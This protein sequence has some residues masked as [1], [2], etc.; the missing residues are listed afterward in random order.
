MISDTRGGE[1]PTGSKTPGG[2]GHTRQTHDPHKP[3]QNHLSPQSSEL[4]PLSSP[5]D[6]ATH[7]SRRALTRQTTSEPRNAPV[8]VATNHRT[9]LTRSKG[10]G[11]I[12]YIVFRSGFLS[13]S[14][15][16]LLRVLGSRLES[17][18]IGRYTFD[19]SF[20]FPFRGWFEVSGLFFAGGR[21]ATS[22][23]PVI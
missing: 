16:S 19:C 5:T 6:P 15:V 17:F 1:S 20:G 8:A 23:R 4:S 11:C 7:L 18:G 14:Y 22:D 3:P 2:A 13:D 10:L 21:C 9:P 12:S